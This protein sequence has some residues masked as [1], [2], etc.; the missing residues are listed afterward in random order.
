[1]LYPHLESPSRGRARCRRTDGTVRT[2]EGEEEAAG[3]FGRAGEGLERRGL[4]R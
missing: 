2:N 1:M 3:I 4:H